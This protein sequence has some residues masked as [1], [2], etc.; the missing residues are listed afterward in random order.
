MGPFLILDGFVRL[1]RGGS[2]LDE[3]L[4]GNVRRVVFITGAG[5]FY[6]FR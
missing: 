1:Q 2:L 3:T 4:D 6:G 5:L